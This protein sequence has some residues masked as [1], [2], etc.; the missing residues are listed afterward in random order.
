MS[1]VAEPIL[2]VDMDAFFA[3]VEQRDDPALRGLPVVVG[4]AGGRGVV[5]AASYEARRFGVRSAMP[6]VR[7]RRLCPHLV[8]APHRFEAYREASRQVMEILQGYTPLV[9]PLS[10]DEAFLDVSGAV[11]LFGPP[12]EIARRI[13]LEVREQVAL[14]CSIGVGSTK[15]VA[16]LLSA[17]AKPDGLLHWP[18][19][20][21]GARLRPLHVSELWGAG[22]K[23][24]ERLTA[25]GFRTVGQLAD[26]D[27]RT[28]QRVVGEVTG[29]HLHHLAHGRDP[30]S[31]TPTNPT[32]SVS[33]EQTYDED[34]DD[35][36]VL[37]RQLLRLCEK[38]GR[39]LRTAGLA[40]RTITLKVRFASFETV[41]RS[42]TLPAPTDRTHDLV[43]V[44]TG[45]LDGLRLERARVRLLG[46]G[47]SNVGD[48]DTARQLSLDAPAELFPLEATGDAT[49]WSDRRWEDVD[50]VADTV[51]ERFGGLGVSFAALLDDD[52]DEARPGRDGRH[53]DG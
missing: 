42:S 41:T 50:R 18:A 36:D 49:G 33:A 7:A 16:K 10:I 2:H 37:R 5:A 43:T 14:P 52:D 22:P 6:M 45:L 28:L 30:R 53:D 20:E 34:I 17:K 21:V 38:V 11:R 12:V 39:R 19:D 8:V 29:N 15:S 51:A 46:V 32:K 31:V 26:A 13:R 27:L 9:E 48:G 1:G 3:S 35:P 44:A 24:V 25:Y 40:G 4:G 23:T 47:V